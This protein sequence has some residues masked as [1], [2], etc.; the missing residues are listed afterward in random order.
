MRYSYFGHAGLALCAA[1]LAQGLWRLAR[2]PTA[3]HPADAPGKAPARPRRTRNFR[4][5]R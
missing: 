2:R 4:P 5:A 3:E 1:A